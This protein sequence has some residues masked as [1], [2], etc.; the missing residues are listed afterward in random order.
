MSRWSRYES[1]VDQ[2]IRMAQERGD[3][4]DLPGK[5][6]PL[7]GLDGPSDDLWWVREYVRREGLSTDAL[8]PPSL[9]LRKEVERLAETV[10]GLSSERAVRE[11]V[12][13]L[14]AR[15]A[16][17]LR[18]PSGPAVPLRPVVADEVVG[19]WR[20]DRKATVARRESRAPR[21][22]NPAGSP[23]RPGR[24]RRLFRRRSKSL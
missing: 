23:A 15:I 22:A 7:R 12:V 9:Q 5:G 4:D 8:L 24:W 19:R 16:S 18:T 2:Q 6:K 10:R 3:F 11:V 14:N 17:W 1:V 13:D 20:A 21:P